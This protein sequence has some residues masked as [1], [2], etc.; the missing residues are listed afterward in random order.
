MSQSQQTSQNVEPVATPSFTLLLSNIVLFVWLSS[1]FI[2][3]EFIGVDVEN[4]SASFCYGLCTRPQ[5]F[6]FRI[7]LILVP[8]VVVYCWI[9]LRYHL[10]L[11]SGLGTVLYDFTHF[12]SVRY[13]YVL[14][15]G[16]LQAGSFF[17]LWLSYSVLQLSSLPDYSIFPVT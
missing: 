17:I 3:F 10:C 8:A 7:C 9:I 12:N 13:F 11:K 16:M 6:L 4:T 2:F 5:L 15:H 1:C 14:L